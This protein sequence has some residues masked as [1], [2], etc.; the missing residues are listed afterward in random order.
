M[1]RLRKEDVLSFI[2]ITTLKT[3]AVNICIKGCTGIQDVFIRGDKFVVIDLYLADYAVFIMPFLK[4]LKYFV[5]FPPSL[6]HL[7][8]DLKIAPLVLF[9]YLFKFSLLFP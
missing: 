7:H 9:Y 2:A 3:A 6:Y 5:F 8:F 1:I 4:A